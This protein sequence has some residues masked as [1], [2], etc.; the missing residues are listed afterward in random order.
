MIK[1]EAYGKGTGHWV[2][3]YEEKDL[4]DLLVAT[5]RATSI[6]RDEWE[7]LGSKDYGSCTGGKGLRVWMRK[8]RKRSAQEVTVVPAPPVQGN[9]AAYDSHKLALEYLEILGSAAVY[10]DGW[11]D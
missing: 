8:P 3:A 9:M 6:W 4:G 10:Y 1:I 11:M 5:R 7:R 2:D